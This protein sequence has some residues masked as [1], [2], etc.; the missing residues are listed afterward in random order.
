M[1]FFYI[2][3]KLTFNFYSFFAQVTENFDI[4]VGCTDAQECEY[5]E[6]LP[7]FVWLLR[8]SDFEL[9]NDE[10]GEMITITKHVATKILQQ[11]GVASTTPVSRTLL[12]L[13]KSFECIQI[14]HPYSK[15][16]ASMP[17]NRLRPEFNE[18][19]ENSIKHI[20]SLIHPR[21]GMDDETELDG[22]LLA[23]LAENYV[24]ELNKPES[25]PNLAVSYENAV[26]THIRDLANSLTLKYN[27]EMELSMTCSKVPFEEG[28]L[29]LPSENPSTNPTLFDFHRCI[30]QPKIKKLQQE[31][32]KYMASSS[33]SEAREYLLATF[34]DTIIKHANNKIEPGCCLYTHVTKNRE[35]SEMFCQSTFNREYWKLADDINTET[36]KKN[37]LAQA[38]GPAKQEV[39]QS[40]LLEI[41]TSPAHFTESQIG[42]DNVAVTWSVHEQGSVSYEIKTVRQDVKA[43]LI[44]TRTVTCSQPP[45][46]LSSLTPNTRYHLQVRAC[47]LEYKGMYSQPLTI[48]T[49][50]GQPGKPEKPKIEVESPSRAKVIIKRLSFEDL[51]GAD[52][53]DSVVL[54]AAFQEDM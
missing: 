19:I 1:F 9:S 38:I 46:T 5:R 24:K 25:I 20:V 11:S 30:F 12:T 22:V 18:G 13:F 33:F 40:K 4:H 45:V 21:K 3:G 29:E 42:V 6:C 15:D 53:V 50:A 52:H 28:N 26:Q 37:Y 14:P 49:L 17:M 39:L 32:D 27:E 2:T 23:K 41:P 16:L 34:Q 31:I 35:K 47:G 43:N 7:D 8:D 54:E 36:L 10:S 48:T 44:Q 51:H